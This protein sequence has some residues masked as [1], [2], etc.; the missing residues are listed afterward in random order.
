MPEG[1]LLDFIN[2]FY[3]LLLADLSTDHDSYVISRE[4]RFYLELEKVPEKLLAL[5]SLFKLTMPEKYML[6]LAISAELRPEISYLFGRLIQQSS[7]ISLSMNVAL[8]LFDLDFFTVYA[9]KSSIRSWELVCLDTE[10]PITMAEIKINKR[11]LFYLLDIEAVEHAISALFARLEAEQTLYLGEDRAETLNSLAHT[12]ET[13]FYANINSLSDL[14]PVQVL[15]DN[16]RIK[17]YIVAKTCDALDIPIYKV[18][19]QLIP[20]KVYELEKFNCLIAREILLTNA[21]IYIKCDETAAQEESVH[22]IRHTAIDHLVKLIPNRCI[23]EAEY[24]LPWLTGNSAI[25][26][27]EAQSFT[28]KMLSWKKIFHHYVDLDVN[29][30]ANIVQQFQL[31]NEQIQNVAIS[32]Q[33]YDYQKLNKQ[34]LMQNIWSL[35]KKQASAETNRHI[36]KKEPNISLEDIILTDQQRKQIN[37]VISHVKY[38]HQVYQQLD[39]KDKFTRGKGVSVL[40]SGTSGTGKTLSAEAIANKLNLDLYHIELSAVISKYIGETE[41]NLEKVFSLAEKTGAV[42]LF[43]E[44]DALFGKR[45]SVKDSRDRYANVEVSYLLQRIENYQ[46][47]SILTT[48]LLSSIDSA[49]LR[50]FK[51]IIEYS[52][53][54]TAQRRTMWDRLLAK[55]NNDVSLADLVELESLEITHA[56]IHNIVLNACFEAADEDKMLSLDYLL[57]ASYYEFLKLKRKLPDYFQDK[58]CSMIA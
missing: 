53:P 49:F 33:E 52:E 16:D 56:S 37:L 48:N 26:S 12:L 58:A 3:A 28:E 4:V 27:I 21:L 15:G 23:L 2:K 13:N 5:F 30:I 20:I 39:A 34:A 6:L 46:G 54:D 19:L 40:L 44:A 24:S 18:D 10:A 1:P 35:C 36:R 31:S 51:F 43:D 14:H 7:A 29:E 47:I 41:Q 9:N 25:F 50:R 32:L 55:V 8:A 17:Q 42:L 45:S 22:Y 57:K 38:R 11:I